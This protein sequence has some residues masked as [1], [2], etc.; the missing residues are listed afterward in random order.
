MKKK[1]FII[2]ILL[3]LLF[4]PTPVYASAGG[5]SAGGG[6]GG[7]GGSHSSHSHNNGYDSTRKNNPY[8]L[9]IFVGFVV[10]TGNIYAIYHLK[11]AKEKDTM[12]RKLIKSFAL[13]DPLWNRKRLKKRVKK[14]FYQAQDAWTNQ[15]TDDFVDILTP[16]LYQNWCIQIEWQI[17]K[18]DRNILRNIHLLTISFVDIYD[19]DNNDNDCFCVYIQALMVD[20]M[21]SESHSY[22]F[23]RLPALLSEYWYFKRIDDEF[24]L[25]YIEQIDEVNPNK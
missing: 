22:D 9:P 12:N 16:D 19:D 23:L 17:Y 1:R 7:S 4:I 10:V 3:L 11:K 15:N 21:Q 14:V 5:G 8:S 18:G 13:H 6:G 20:Y 25:D 24:Y 2:T